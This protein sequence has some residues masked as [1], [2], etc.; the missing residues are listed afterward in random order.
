MKV[1]AGV[2]AAV[3]LAAVAFAGP[4]RVAP[5]VYTQPDSSTL[6]VTRAGDEHF[7]YATTSD[8][9]LIA[10]DSAKVFRFVKNDGTLS[11]VQAS[12][13]GSRSD[14]AEALLSE[15]SPTLALEAYRESFVDPIAVIEAAG[16]SATEA[17][18][19]ASLAYRP[20]APAYTTGEQRFPV[21]LLSTNG[22]T[23]QDSALIYRMLNEE[24]F[25]E[26]GM[27]GSV[28]DYFI[29][30][31]D[32]Q[33]FPTFDLFS[34]TLDVDLDTATDYAVARFIVSFA[35]SLKSLGFTASNY[36]ADGD[37]T[38]DLLAIIF[39]GSENDTQIWS[40]YAAT[41]VNYKIN[42]KYTINPYLVV[43]ELDT[44]DTTLLAGIGIF[45][46]EFSHSL[47]LGDHYDVTTGTGGTYLHDVMAQGLYL[48]YYG[49]ASARNPPTF[50]AFERE[51]AGWLTLTELS[52][53][54]SLLPPIYENFAY[55]VTNPDN[56]D[57]YYV[58]EYRPDTLW[59]DAGLY[60]NGVFIWYVNYDED[61]WEANTIN[62]GS[63]EHFKVVPASDSYWSYA[64]FPG[65]TNTTEFDGFVFETGSAD[66][67]GIALYSISLSSAY[68]S[69][70][71][72]PDTTLS[73]TTSADTTSTDSTGTEEGEEGE[74]GETEDGSD[75][76]GIAAS[77]VKSFSASW[78]DFGL[79]VN[80][81]RG[82]TL[83]VYDLK[84]NLVYSA[85]VASESA[86][87]KPNLKNSAYL[88][89]VGA[90]TLGIF[91]S[92]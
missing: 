18:S 20:T 41:S 77:P 89:K 8:G 76:T 55:S 73:D 15:I 69:F 26:Q 21:I 84:G 79:C 58:I 62:I 4:A 11:E 43:P 72:W 40:H 80:G 54:D 59:D 31:S 35:S 33:F 22:H 78:S 56:E 82:K 37:K 30:A 23:I 91:R 1:F 32:S 60:A 81:A 10:R 25:S 49:D 14:A 86:V 36:D 47:G 44:Y 13:P 39:A 63:D 17:T 64:P 68:A 5:R 48:G 3:C 16:D 42:P 66:S 29:F 90:S 51:S 9:Y 85:R 45:S 28:R 52:E 67:A 19:T 88:V 27:Y 12:D 46:H 70:H 50:N 6:M 75:E 87:F 74:E 34:V 53:S 57:E 24:G 2:F 7:N 71:T 83:K 61:V 38:I 92:F 65:S